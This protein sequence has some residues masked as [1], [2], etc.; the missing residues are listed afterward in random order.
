MSEDER[1]KKEVKKM[2]LCIILQVKFGCRCVKNETLP[3]CKAV[4]E[5]YQEC[6]NH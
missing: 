6:L 2:K 5:L 3:F 4:E 1:L